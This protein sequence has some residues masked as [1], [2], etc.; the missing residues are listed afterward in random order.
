MLGPGPGQYESLKGS[1]KT[2]E[3]VKSMKF[4]TGHRSSMENLQTKNFPGPS[5]LPNM[6][7]IKN[8]SPNFGF[9]SEKRKPMANEKM[10]PGPGNYPIQS[11]IGKEGRHVSMHSLIKY[12]PIEK[13]QKA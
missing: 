3:S 12:S 9:G 4:G 11:K 1:L 6:G 5:L 8:S 2:K 13:E 7:A 10:S